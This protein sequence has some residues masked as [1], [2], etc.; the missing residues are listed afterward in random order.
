M[1]YKENN[2]YRIITTN[3]ESIVKCKIETDH[4]ENN[5]IVFRVLISSKYT[6]RVAF[7]LS[8]INQYINVGLIKIEE[9]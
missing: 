3:N 7:R 2:L 6:T 9:L 5:G 8:F 4:I 1:K